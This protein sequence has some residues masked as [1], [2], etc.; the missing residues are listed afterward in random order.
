MRDE[1]RDMTGVIGDPFL[2][3]FNPIEDRGNLPLGPACVTAV[4][5]GEE[6][7]EEQKADNQQVGNIHR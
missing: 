2:A 3:L 1:V 5:E 7:A 6:Q 4:K